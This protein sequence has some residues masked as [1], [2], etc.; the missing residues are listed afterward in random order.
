M[1]ASSITHNMMH[2]LSAPHRIFLYTIWSMSRIFSSMLCSCD[3]DHDQ[4]NSLYR[5]AYAR[6]LKLAMSRRLKLGTNINVYVCMLWSLARLGVGMHKHMCRFNINIAHLLNLSKWLYLHYVFVCE[7]E[8]CLFAEGWGTG[9]VRSP[10][11]LSVRILLTVST[12]IL[13]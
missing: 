11:Q 13:S 5:T 2:S 7:N 12:Q 6:R 3:E 10:H 4:L 9:S 1:F 8:D